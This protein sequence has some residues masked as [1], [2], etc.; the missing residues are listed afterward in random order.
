MSCSRL[1]CIVRPSCCISDSP[2]TEQQAPAVY[3]TGA[4]ILLQR[5]HSTIT[6]LPCASFCPRRSPRA[7]RGRTLTQRLQ[8]RM[9]QPKR[10]SPIQGSPGTLTTRNQQ[11]RQPRPTIQ[12]TSACWNRRV[13]APAVRC[14]SSSHAASFCESSPALDASLHLQ[15]GPYAATA[16]VGNISQVQCAVK[17]PNRWCGQMYA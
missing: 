16:T 2:V 8:G 11:N 6:F 9:P 4:F 5:L 15:G 10:Q 13:C 7:C 3:S 12:A 1:T 14:S 17:R